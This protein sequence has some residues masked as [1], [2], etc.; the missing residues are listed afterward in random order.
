MENTMRIW[1]QVVE[2]LESAHG[3]SRLFRNSHQLP[4]DLM[5]LKALRPHRRPGRGS[6]N[7]VLGSHN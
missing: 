5:H 2:C 7:N 4:D 6:V 3:L 1:S